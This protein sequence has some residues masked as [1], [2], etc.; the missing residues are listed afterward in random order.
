MP[1]RPTC[2]TQP[3]YK[4]CLFFDYTDWF[5][6]HEHFCLI[7]ELLF[8]NFSSLN[9]HFDILMV[10]VHPLDSLGPKPHANDHSS[11]APQARNQ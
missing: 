8:D 7:F 2:Y 4:P 11:K 1:K 5:I 10:E 6:S 3:V 9:Q